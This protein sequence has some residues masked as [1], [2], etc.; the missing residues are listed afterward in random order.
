[1]TKMSKKECFFTWRSTWNGAPHAVVTKDEAE[2]R[3]WLEVS[4]E[5]ADPFQGQ[6]SY[7]RRNCFSERVTSGKCIPASARMAGAPFSVFS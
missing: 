6:T 5:E 3:I 1:M 4:I 2:S 7:R